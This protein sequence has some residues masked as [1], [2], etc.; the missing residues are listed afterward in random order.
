MV[1]NR[2]L[3]GLKGKVTGKENLVSISRVLTPAWASGRSFKRAWILRMKEMGTRSSN[4][5][6][7]VYRLRIL[8]ICNQHQHNETLNWNT[9]CGTVYH[10]HPHIETL[11]C[12]TTCN[13]H[14]HTDTPE[15]GI[16]FHQHQ[17]VETPD[18]GLSINMYTYNHLLQSTQWNTGV[19]PSAI[20]TNRMKHWSVGPSA[21]NTIRFKHWNVG[22]FAINTNRIKH[23]CVRLSAINANRIKH[24]VWDY[25]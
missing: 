17:P 25:L 13:Q 15:C 22:L 11:E 1:S 3:E 23:W 9:G 21:I 12:W 18:M 24:R 14:Q 5:S 16:I 8:T 20:N 4:S 7:G 10:Q 2:M 19:G 6:T